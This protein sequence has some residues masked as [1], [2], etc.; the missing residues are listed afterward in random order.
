MA[1]Q[2]HSPVSPDGAGAAIG[3]PSEPVMAQVCESSKERSVR[4]ESTPTVPVRWREIAAVVLLVALADV[5]L[6]RG[7]GFTGYALGLAVA[8]FLLALGMPALR[9]RASAGIVGGM[10][11]LAVAKLAWCGDALLAAVG[12]VVLLA[13]T[14]TLM[15]RTPYILDVALFALQVPVAGGW[16]LSQYRQTAS[17]L[18]WR[19]TRGGWLGVLLPLV[20]LSA[21]GTI[22]IL[23]NPDLTTSVREAVRRG[24]D[25]LWNWWIHYG[26]TGTEL[27]FWLVAGWAAIGL[28]R[29]VVQRSLLARSC[30]AASGGIPVPSSQEF[31]LYTALRNMLAAVIVLFA[32]YLV[33]EF[34][35]LWFRPFPKGFYY[36]GY[37]HEG[38]AWL[39]VALALATG[40]LSLVFR[41]NVLL[42]PRLPRLRRLAW[43]WSAE[44]L[45]LAL[46]V[47]NRLFI[48][49]HFNGM[50]RMR[51]VGLIGMTAVV[52]GF[53]WVVWKIAYQHDFVWLVRRHLWTLAIAIYVLAVLPVDTLAHHYNVRRVLAGDLAP[54]VQIAVHPIDAEGILVLA[55]LLECPD[56]IIRE[57]IAA[58]LAQ[59]S[60]TLEAQ[61]QQ[62]SPS[63]W[64]S[65][66]GA[67]RALLHQLRALAPQLQEY[68]Q[69]S[70]RAL[71]RFRQ[72]TDQWY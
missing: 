18:P 50:T 45:V 3:S 27:L 72:Y 43:I 8:P 46:A 52:I 4:P 24:Y 10:L 6:Y 32:V 60:E 56:P 39:T 26:P 1:E 15:G 64:R 21:F 67:D 28:L 16:G 33:F 34:K 48:Y 61:A 30:P 20:V 13:L 17:R 40:L 38:A 41:G 12:G 70:Q 42:D 62:R 5:T 47:Y 7:P 69:D 49:I 35:T 22:F 57:G 53:V 14:M 31:S 9:P 11:L 44:N 71:A 29:P 66:Q 51:T 68:R 37:A 2:P 54:S 23:A 19:G 63:E 25:A 36:A 65:W 59:Q 55:P 58:M